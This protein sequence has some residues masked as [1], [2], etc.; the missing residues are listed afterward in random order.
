MWKHYRY[1][2]CFNTF[3]ATTICVVEYVAAVVRCHDTARNGGGDVVAGS[4]VAVS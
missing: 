1:R 2:E 4:V 3:T